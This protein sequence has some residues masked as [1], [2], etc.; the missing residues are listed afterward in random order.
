ML[1]LY[2]ILT[3][4]LFLFFLPL[5]LLVSLLKKKYRGRTMQRLGLTLHGQPTKPAGSNVP[6]I[7]VHALSVGEV[8]SALPRIIGLRKRYP[9]GLLYF[10]TTTST[11]QTTAKQLSKGI[12]DAVFFSPFDF[13]F[14]L[15][16]FLN[17]LKPSLFVLVETDLWPGWLYCLKKRQ[18]PALL[19]NGRFSKKSLATYR[20]FSFLFRPM[21]DCFSLIAMQTGQDAESLRS[22]D[23]PPERIT[24][25]GNLK[26]DAAL[27]KK[28][29]AEQKKIS[30]ADLQLPQD[31]PL[32]ICGSTHR[33]EEK[34][35]FAAFQ[36]IKKKIPDCCLLIAPRDINRAGEI[37]TEAEKYTLPTSRRSL[38]SPKT[39]IVILDTLGEL[40]SCYQLADIAF[41]GGSL[42]P[43]GGHNPLEAASCGRPVLF[44]P[45][46]DDFSEIS[47]DLVAAGGAQMVGTSD[48]L[49]GQVLTLLTS[50]QRATAMGTAARSLVL[51]HQGVIQHHLEVIE[52]LLH[53]PVF[54]GND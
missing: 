27:T 24:T 17:L 28:S 18:I 4:I 16:H 34:I 44:G 33:G 14:S 42:V 49:A 40:S 26:F 29:P 13:F 52:Q 7:W 47:R 8:T 48:E 45:F 3:T 50:A 11:G 10:S 15:Q 46:M 54:P 39:D 51:D 41:I 32:L 2:T 31:G 20:R 5:I 35:I 25:L 43:A 21:F 9:D 53:P 6:V 19:V 36:K 12:V 37:E 30:R 22:F 1:Q 23:I 38:T